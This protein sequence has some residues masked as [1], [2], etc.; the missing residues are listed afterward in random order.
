M[1]VLQVTNV[2]TGEI[3]SMSSNDPVNRMVAEKLVEILRRNGEKA[4]EEKPEGW[5]VVELDDN[6]VALD[7]DCA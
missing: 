1:G 6:V 7:G 4:G 3:A 2:L 5:T